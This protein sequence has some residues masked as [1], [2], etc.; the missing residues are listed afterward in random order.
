MRDVSLRWGLG[1]GAVSAVLGTIAL[2]AGSVVEPVQRV[3]TAEA[4]A[5]AIFI[6]GILVLVTLGIA[7]GLSYYAG[8]RAERARLNEDAAAAADAASVAGS[9]ATGTEGAQ[10]QRSVAVLAGGVTMFCYWMITSLYMFVLPPSTQ[11]STAQ[12][13]TLS[14]VENRLLFGII[15]VLFGLGLGGLG[16]RAPAARLLLDRIIKSPVPVAIAVAPVGASAAGGTTLPS[17]NVSTPTAA[18]STPIMPIMPITPALPIMPA[19]P[20]PAEPADAPRNAASQAGATTPVA[21]PHVG[22]DDASA[23]DQL[24]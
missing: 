5:L 21:E 9:S 15:F 19:S 4:A 17:V 2:I 3:T 6:R 11:P 1:M 23:P 8:L 18:P 12:V 16:G 10:N 20:A 7:L 14:F 22:H 13:D 24:P